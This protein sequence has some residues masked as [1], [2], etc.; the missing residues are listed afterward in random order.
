MTDGSGS[1]VFTGSGCACGGPDDCVCDEMSNEEN[2]PEKEDT[3]KEERDS[4][5]WW[6][7]QAAKPKAGGAAQ[8]VHGKEEVIFHEIPDLPSVSEAQIDGC[9]PHG[10]SV[11]I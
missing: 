7:A 11:G 6:Q 8:G 10:G 4:Q 9:P 1:N 3:A 5:A 2:S